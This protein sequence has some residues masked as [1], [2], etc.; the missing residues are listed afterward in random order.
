MLSI[1]LLISMSF[2]EKFNIYHE[3]IDIKTSEICLL[4]LNDLCNSLSGEKIYKDSIILKKYAIGSCNIEYDYLQ[5][6]KN[7]NFL[8][9]IYLYNTI[10]KD[11]N[12]IA[13][14]IAKIDAA[15]VEQN[16]QCKKFGNNYSVVFDSLKTTTESNIAYLLSECSSNQII[17]QDNRA[18]P[19]IEN[20]TK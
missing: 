12:N 16:T 8:Q 14:N 1:L 13:Y 20:D 18:I 15:R 4:V 3:C 7:N 5:K 6:Y 11:N 19:Y 17:F 10:E 9:T 2:S